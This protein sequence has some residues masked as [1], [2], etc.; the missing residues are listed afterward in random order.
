MYNETHWVTN[1]LIVPTSSNKRKSTPKHCVGVLKNIFQNYLGKSF[2]CRPLH[3]FQ[4]KITQ[5][6]STSKNCVGVLKNIFQNSVEKSFIS[7][8]LHLLQ[9]KITQTQST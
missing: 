6:Q 8:Q 7:R 5:T 9:D 1:L 3:L 4:D 2:V